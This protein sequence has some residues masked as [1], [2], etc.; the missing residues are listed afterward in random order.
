MQLEL[1]DITPIIQPTN[2]YKVHIDFYFGD[3][4]GYDQR[5]FFVKKDEINSFIYELI[6]VDSQFT[7]GRGGSRK[8]Y[9]QLNYF[10]PE[11]SND[12][13][14]KWLADC[15]YDYNQNYTIDKYKI[16]YFNL[17]GIEKHVDVRGT[18]NFE[19][20]V[21]AYNISKSIG[22]FAVWDD[23]IATNES[24]QNYFNGIASIIE[25]YLLNE[26]M[27]NA[28]SRSKQKNKI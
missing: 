15:P 2:I 3:A 19:E 7:H 10:L 1:S 5:D 24:Y 27:P 21:K 22:D 4:D 8:M 20:D 25:S 23:D 18:E 16:T 13:K 28:N 26:N 17:N 9:D 14:F 11:G 6:A 12:S